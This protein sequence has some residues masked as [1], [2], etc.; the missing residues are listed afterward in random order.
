MRFRRTEGLPGTEAGR[1][2]ARYFIPLP[3]FRRDNFTEGEKRETDG[4]DI[5]HVAML[6]GG[7]T[8]DCLPRSSREET[9][10]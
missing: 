6:S 3:R 8:P 9:F 10:S 1:S 2:H 7:K 4:N 5:R